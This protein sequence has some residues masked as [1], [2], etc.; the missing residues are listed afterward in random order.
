MSPDEG[1]LDWNVTGKSITL[2]YGL[3][4]FYFLIV[5][6]LEY[7]HD[8]ASG[9]IVGHFLRQMRG[10]FNHLIL[11]MYGLK[12]VNN[13]FYLD[14]GL[15]DLSTNEDITRE[16]IFVKNHDKLHETAPLVMRDLWKIYPPSIGFIGSICSLFR[17]PK[18]CSNNSWSDKES[19]DKQSLPRRA[20]RGLSVAVQKGE[21][22]GLLGSNGA[23]KTTALSV[24]TGDLA[25]TSGQAFVAGHDIT[26]TVPGGVTEARKNIG[27]CPQIDPL[28]DL[29]TGRETLEMYAKLRG[30]SSEQVNALVDDL[31]CNLTLSP[32]AD[33][34]SRSYS[35]G[36]KRKLSLGIAALVGDGGLL[37]IDECSSGLDPLARKK[38]WGLI[39]SL[40]YE[41]SVI[42]TTHSMEE[43][44]A[45]CSRV[46]IMANGQ[47]VALGPVQHLKT[48]YFDGYTIDIN[49]YQNTP[50]KDVSA[51][52]IKLV[53]NV[54]PGSH[55]SESNG[56]F[57]KLEL[58]R[59]SRIGLGGIFQRLQRFKHNE[60]YVE[61]YSIAQ[62]SLEQV[63]IKLMKDEGERRQSIRDEN[64]FP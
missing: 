22:F 21:T 16:E 28:L 61:N 20:V 37:L 33:K 17:V 47:F 42:I 36:N 40:A 57:L 34:T 26:G 29:M 55:L 56:R 5:L 38:L 9:G 43:A 53:E 48:K 14:D 8:G 3:A 27:F 52:A 18:C 10:F 39:Q 45:L 25:P 63:F 12:K 30:V 58:S 62:C 7:S 50:N 19:N 60:N 15:G 1:V 51:I 24:L 11:Q 41:R 31:L 46:G 59:I 2:L 64:V 54:F 49:C 32:F 44:E 4:P 13:R 35:G 23:G 6:F